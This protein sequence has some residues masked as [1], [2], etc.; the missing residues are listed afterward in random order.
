[1]GVHSPGEDQNL[2]E[3]GS[4]TKK[5]SFLQVKKQR[6]RGGQNKDSRVVRRRGNG[7]RPHEL[8][9]IGR[10]RQ[11]REGRYEKRRRGDHKRRKEKIARRK[12]KG[13]DSQERRP[14]RWL[15]WAEKYEP[16]KLEKTG[17]VDGH[18]PGGVQ[19]LGLKP[20]ETAERGRED[21]R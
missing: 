18:Q 16:G 11:R 12:K 2:K 5:G 1:V 4:S 14:R 17:A 6:R 7:L 20:I 21:T 13:W 3:K 15:R 10:G 8:T 9:K 19:G